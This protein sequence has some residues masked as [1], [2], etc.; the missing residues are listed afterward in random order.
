[1]HVFTDDQIPNREKSR[2]IAHVVLLL[3]NA[4]FAGKI[5]IFGGKA[6]IFAGKTNIFAA[7]A[8]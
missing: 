2:E 6:D 3:V 5:H 8:K 1:M 4:I 7:K